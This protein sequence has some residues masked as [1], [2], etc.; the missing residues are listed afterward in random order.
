[1]E[2][3]GQHEAVALG[4]RAARGLSDRVDVVAGCLSGLDRISHIYD[5][6]P[7]GVANRGGRCDPS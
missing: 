4:P 2:N 1:M 3:A 5:H 7:S 6:V